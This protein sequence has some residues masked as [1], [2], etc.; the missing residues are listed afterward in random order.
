[1]RELI[2]HD[3]QVTYRDWCNKFLKKFN[4]R[5]FKRQFENYGIILV[6]V[7]TLVSRNKTP[8]ST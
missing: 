2:M 4:G 1:V 6:T 3:R 8:L 5:V 7:G